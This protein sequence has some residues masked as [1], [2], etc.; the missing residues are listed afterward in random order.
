MALNGKAK[1][2]QTLYS[3]RGKMHIFSQRLISKHANV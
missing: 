2:R 1:Q 3:L